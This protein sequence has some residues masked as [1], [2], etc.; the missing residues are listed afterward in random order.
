MS[1]PDSVIIDDSDSSILYEEGKWITDTSS[2]NYTVSGRPFNNTAHI[3]F[4]QASFT[5]RFQ[6]TGIELWGLSSS[7]GV[8]NGTTN[9]HLIDSLSS[10]FGGSTAPGE[11]PSFRFSAGYDPTEWQEGSINALTMTVTGTK[12]NPVAFDFARFMPSGFSKPEDITVGVMEYTVSD[13]FTYGAAPPGWDSSDFL[14]TTTPDAPYTFSFTGTSVAGLGGNGVN[15]S[16]IQ[17]MASYSIDGGDPVK[18]TVNNLATSVLDTITEQTI[19]QTNQVAPGNHTIQ[20]VYHG[21]STTTP[22]TLMSLLVTGT[23][24]ILSVDPPPPAKPSSSSL[25]NPSSSNPSPVPSN[26]SHPKTHRGIIA[27]AV[28]VSV[29]L[30]VLLCLIGFLLYRR[31]KRRLES[32]RF[33]SYSLDP[34]PVAMAIVPFFDYSA[35]SIR[36]GDSVGEASEKNSS[37][38]HVGQVETQQNSLPAS[39]AP[40]RVV[41]RVHE[42]SGEVPIQPVEQIVVVDIP[43]SYT[44]LND[45]AQREEGPREVDPLLK[46]RSSYKP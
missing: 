13:D 9:G 39:S 2:L 23:K 22:L 36:N 25:S 27:A 40:I 8:W 37:Q 44:S 41:T 12:D 3:T 31:R 4:Q 5:I 42:D 18:F 30:V 21:N 28:A 34:G 17:A 6:G 14:S 19:F 20:I 32:K 24:T 35:L 38:T 15:D 33:S 26:S 45:R 16:H 1:L 7:S 43:P 11:Q 46:A 29:I 10:S